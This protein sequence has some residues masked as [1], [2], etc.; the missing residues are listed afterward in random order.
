MYKFGLKDGEKRI[1]VFLADEQIQVTEHTVPMGSKWLTFI[2]SKDENCF[3]CGTG[4]RGTDTIWSSFLDLTPYKGSDGKEYKYSK[5]GFV[6]TGNSIDLL[7]RRRAEKGGDLTGWKVEV[8][9]DGEK[10]PRCGNDITLKEK[11]DLTKLAADIAKPLDWEKILAPQPASIIQARLRFA[12]A[13]VDTQKRTD[14][15]KTPADAGA[16]TETED[17]D[18]PF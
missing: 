6:A 15:T 4:V 10:S 9:R 5:K 11:V 13:P 1:G 8:F 18:I 2:C 12:G 16:S 17:S 7:A 3:G 14:L